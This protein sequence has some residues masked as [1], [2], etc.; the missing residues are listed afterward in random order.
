MPDSRSH[1]KAYVCLHIFD[2]SRPVLL[3]VRSDRDWQFLCGAEHE[4]VAA[5]YR[6]VGAGHIFDRDPTLKELGDLAE[7]W[8]AE[9][10]SVRDAW[11]RKPSG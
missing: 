9:R 11:V 10:S 3:V 2:A 5:N 8:E 7:N 6:I 4:D 1:E